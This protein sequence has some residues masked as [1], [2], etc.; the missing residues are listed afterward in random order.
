MTAPRKIKW[1]IAHHPE[2]LFVRTAELFRNLL[3]K[4]CPGQFELEILTTQQY[5]E[6]Y[7]RLHVLG[8]CGPVTALDSAYT[9]SQFQKP[10][11]TWAE[12]NSQKWPALFEALKDG[13]FDLSQT[14]IS[15]IGGSILRDFAALD[16]P[17][18][19]NDHDH[20]SRVLDHEIGDNLCKKLADK[21]GI[22]GLAFTYSGGYR[23][24]GGNQG[25]ASLTDLA[26]VPMLT[27]S[28]FASKLFSDVGATTLTTMASD[29]SDLQ[30]LSATP[31]AMVETT[32]LRFKGK[33]ILKTNHSM[34]LTSILTGEKFWN[35]LTNHQQT[36]FMTIAKIVAKTERTW[37]VEDAEKYET[38]AASRGISIVDISE[39]DAEQLKQ[40]SKYVYD[41][42]KSH[43]VKFVK[44]IPNEIDPEELSELVDLIKSKAN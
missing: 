21:T 17:F 19:F 38:D 20:V 15:V 4:F 37:S 29:E 26:G 2:Y 36:A 31:N 25:V 34:F 9:G 22:R 35:S 18:L 3:N 6:K 8:S 43:N 44:P 10:S 13:E 28:V 11:K 14:Q 16:L 40:S 27:Q 30:N 39:E 42:I 23:I 12:H 5:V 1:L 32:Y 7:D 33:N 24:V 41:D